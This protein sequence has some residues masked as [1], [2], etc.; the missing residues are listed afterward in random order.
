[1]PIVVTRSI[2]TPLL[3][4]VAQTAVHSAES[5]VVVSEEKKKV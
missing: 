1:M 2:R 5:H 3:I 4:S